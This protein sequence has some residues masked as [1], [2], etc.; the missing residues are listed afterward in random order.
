MLKKD[1]DEKIRLLGL[2]NSEVA[3]GY[4]QQTGKALSAGHIAAMRSGDSDKSVSPYVGMYVEWMLDRQ[5]L[6]LLSESAM[7]VM[8]FL[9]REIDLEKK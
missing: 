2:S 7:R 6:K 5:Q 8:N 4:N 1:F 9:K 3:E